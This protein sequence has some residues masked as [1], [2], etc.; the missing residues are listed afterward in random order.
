MNSENEL[1]GKILGMCFKIHSLLGPGLLE[2]VYEEALVYEL[3][4]NGIDCERQV[5]IPVI[6]ETVRL[7]AGFRVDIVVDG[8]VIIE[9]KSIEEIK[10]VAQETITYLSA[11]VPDEIGPAVKFQRE[12]HERRYN[13]CREPS[14]IFISEKILSF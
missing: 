4:M 12:K 1:S 8:K 14:L 6:Y 9:L 2:S 11:V 13:P 7:D 3:K 5:D 10:T